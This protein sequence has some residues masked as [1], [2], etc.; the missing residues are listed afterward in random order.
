MSLTSAAMCKQCIE[1]T[2]KTIKMRS[3]PTLHSCR[4]LNQ[5]LLLGVSAQSILDQRNPAFSH[6][7]FSRISIQSDLLTFFQNLFVSLG[8]SWSHFPEKAS[9]LDFRY[10]FSP[11]FGHS[12]VVFDLFIE[13]RF[14]HLI[15]CYPI[16]QNRFS[17]L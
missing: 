4:D 1:M 9:A 16:F 8:K 3:K 12:G 11:Q 6:L 10:A 17:F 15:L 7:Y 5:D 13:T 14:L 2:E